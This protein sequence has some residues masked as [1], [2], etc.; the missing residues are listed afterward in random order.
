MYLCVTSLSCPVLVKQNHLLKSIADTDIY[1]C[2][3]NYDC[4]HTG[5]WLSSVHQLALT[6][7]MWQTNCVQRTIEKP[8]MMHLRIHI[9]ARQCLFWCIMSI[10]TCT[11]LSFKTAL[12]G[13]PLL[14]PPCSVG[15]VI[16]V[17]PPPVTP[18]SPPGAM[19]P[20]VVPFCNPP[21]GDGEGI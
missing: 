4:R 2:I 1:T 12:W 6:I 10:E 11:H 15:Y 17:T 18:S 20:P 7:P 8:L 19:T 13:S 21:S 3:H 9:N 14:T 5:N 16:S